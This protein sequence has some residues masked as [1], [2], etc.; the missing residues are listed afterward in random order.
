MAADSTVQLKPVASYQEVTMR[1][2]VRCPA[3][4]GATE[5]GSAEMVKPT[6]LAPKQSAGVMRVG[7]QWATNFT[8]FARIQ[9]LKPFLQVS[10]FRSQVSS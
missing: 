9:V 4:S 2:A 7:A 8:S 1:S 6:G 10:G 5:R 3:L